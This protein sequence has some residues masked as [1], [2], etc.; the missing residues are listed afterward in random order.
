MNVSLIDS[1]ESLFYR[2][3][4]LEYVD[5]SEVIASSINTMNEMFSSSFL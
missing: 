3:S 2:L 5:L 1:F 4:S